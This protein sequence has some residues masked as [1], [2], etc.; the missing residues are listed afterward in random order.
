MTEPLPKLNQPKN[1][2]AQH[3]PQALYDRARLELA[4]ASI[5]ACVGTLM[6]A[7]VAADVATRDRPDWVR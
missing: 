5:R 3:N 2:T 1:K 6:F 7:A 4:A